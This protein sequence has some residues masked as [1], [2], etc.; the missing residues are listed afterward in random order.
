MDAILAGLKQA[1]VLL[2]QGDPEVL[3]VTL[4]SLEVSGVAVLL[5]MLLGMPL[6]VA[7]ALTRFPGRSLLVSAVNTGMGV[8]PV[9]AG[10]AVFMVLARSGPVGILD[11][12]YTPTAMVVAQVV[13]A[14]PIV[15]G[16]TMT[17]MQQLPP[18]LRLQTLGLGASRT[19][20]ILR[21]L[22]E[23]RLP[24]LAAIMAGFGGVI[25]EVGAVLMVGG[26]IQG[27]TRVL[28]TSIVQM[29]RMGRY[30][31]AIAL[32]VILMALVFAV[33]FAL[34]TIQQRGKTT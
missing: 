25:S 9:V 31:L 26:N 28:T 24:L 23:A 15:A 16:L 2:I 34:T 18:K 6:G 19:Q 17:A 29:T 5:S 32:S 30:D 14:S 12:I 21:L 4:L 1:F 10:L 11:L 22:R 7:L 8:P 27:Q 33:N 3:R 20:M 13:I